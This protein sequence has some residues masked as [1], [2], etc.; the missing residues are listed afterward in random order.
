MIII[1][2]EVLIAKYH[3]FEKNRIIKLIINDDL[4]E[5]EKFINNAVLRKLKTVISNEY[6]SHTVSIKRIINLTNVL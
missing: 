3:K 5:K 2:Y 6:E 4:E 1:V